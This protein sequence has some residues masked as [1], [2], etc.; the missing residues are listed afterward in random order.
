MLAFDLA[1]GN[2]LWEFA[3]DGAYSYDEGI[4]DS[5][6]VP[7][8][9]DSDNGIC[10]AFWESWG[11]H[12]S[13]LLTAIGPGSALVWSREWTDDRQRS[14]ELPTHPII[15]ADGLVYLFYSWTE[16]EQGVPQRVF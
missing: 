15:D 7:L 1:T 4:N 16:V 6:G 9:L 12:R 10:Y 5:K 13:Q 8:A 11:Q 3:P 2:F 14:F